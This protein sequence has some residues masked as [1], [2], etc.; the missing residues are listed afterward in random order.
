MII[1]NL[2]N[3]KFGLKKIKFINFRDEIA[4][5]FRRY[6][7]KTLEGISLGVDSPKLISFK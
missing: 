5:M 7:K 2:K 6:K 3:V 1:F 4:I